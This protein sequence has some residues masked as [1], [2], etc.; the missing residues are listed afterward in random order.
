[1]PNE[2]DWYFAALEKPSDIGKALPVHEGD[3][4]PG[5]YRKRRFKQGPFDPVAIWRGDDGKMIALVGAKPSDASEI[6][7]YVCRNPVSEES[8]RDAA[9][10]KGWPDEAPGIGHNA[11]P[12]NDFDTLADQIESARACVADYAQIEDD[13]KQAQAQSARARL[14]ELSREAD[15]RRTEEKA[16]HLEASK[17]VDAK[18][19]PLVKTAK[20]AADDI[21]KAMGAF[22]TAKA[23]KAAEERRRQEDEARKAEEARRAAEAG[24]KTIEPVEIAPP[25]QEPEPVK[26]VVKGGYGR[27]ASVKVVRIATVVDQDAAYQAMRTHPELVRMIAQLAQRAVDAGHEIAGV[28]FEEE[29][30]VA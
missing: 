10:G 22:E 4:K 28:T 23:R 16:P 13:E 14:N 6:W 11:G 17:A 29:R 12:A 7:T 8:Y 2:Y 19:Q 9:A 15:K 27:A 1:M 21:A 5:F 18:W 24:G 20:A 26:T 25:P 3:P 30:R